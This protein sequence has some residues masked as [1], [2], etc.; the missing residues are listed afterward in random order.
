MTVLIFICV[1]VWLLHYSIV[2]KIIGY[3]IFFALIGGGCAL[4]S[5]TFGLTNCLL[6]LILSALVVLIDKPAQP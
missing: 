6:F 3:G 5:S 4:A 2:Q 1:A